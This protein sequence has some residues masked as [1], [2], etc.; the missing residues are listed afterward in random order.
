MTEE[1]KGMLAAGL[2][3]CIFGTTYLFSKIALGI[4]E[5][6]ILLCVRFTITFAVLNLLVLTRAAKVNFRG[7]KVWGPLVLGLLQPVLYFLLMHAMG[8]NVAGVIGSAIAAGF[9]L[10]V[11]GG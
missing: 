7:K 8:P 10:S 9:L 6:A 3:Y 11:F 1:K 4:T 2:A 5:P